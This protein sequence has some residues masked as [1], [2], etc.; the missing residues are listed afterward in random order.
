MQPLI[1]VENER[2]EGGHY[3][4]WQDATVE[5]YQFPNGY[6]N[7]VIAGRR[8]IYYRGM[9]KASGGR[10]IPEY[11]GHGVISEVYED[12]NNDPNGKKQNRN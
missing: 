11:F 1:L 7:K 10:R 5:R 9:R 6:R 12:P 3:D 2:T 4:H 8:F